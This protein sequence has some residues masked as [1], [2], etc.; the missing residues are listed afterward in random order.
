M[1]HSRAWRDGHVNTLDRFLPLKLF[2]IHLEFMIIIILSETTQKLKKK[3]E[4][5]KME[6]YV[7]CFSNSRFLFPLLWLQVTT[8]QDGVCEITS[9]RPGCWCWARRPLIRPVNSNLPSRH[10]TR[11]YK[12]S[13]SQHTSSDK[14]LS[15]SKNIHTASSS[16]QLSFFFHCYKMPPYFFFKSENKNSVGINARLSLVS[17]NKGSAAFSVSA[18]QQISPSQKFSIYF[19]MR[20][21]ELILLYSLA[22]LW[23]AISPLFLSSSTI[24]INGQRRRNPFRYGKLVCRPSGRATPFQLLYMSPLSFNKIHILNRTILNRSQ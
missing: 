13:W 8:S 6:C 2:T 9:A 14:S 5:A 18:C 11:S 4:F 24:E 15:L 10:L 20:E 7:A 19:C 21:R 17:G 12:S 1:A 22:Q 16:F 23:A 3:K